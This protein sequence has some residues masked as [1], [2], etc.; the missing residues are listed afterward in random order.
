[1]HTGDKPFKCDVYNKD[2][3]Q[4]SHLNVHQR[5]HCIQVINRM[6]CIRLAACDW[7]PGI[8]VSIGI[9]VIGMHTYQSGH[10]N[11]HKRLHTGDKPFKCDLCNKGSSRSSHCS[12]FCLSF[13]MAE[14]AT[15][16]VVS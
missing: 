7:Y 12:I 11:M 2:F 14:N 8:L 16:T 6:Q 1:M 13:A 5:L 9:Q 4:S 10:L 3:S 15:N